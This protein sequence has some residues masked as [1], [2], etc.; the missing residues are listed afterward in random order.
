MSDIER[1][2][3][4]L[5]SMNTSD[6]IDV[7]DSVCDRRIYGDGRTV[8]TIQEKRDKTMVVI[9]VSYEHQCTCSRTIDQL[10]TEDELIEY[11]TKELGDTPDEILTVKNDSVSVIIPNWECGSK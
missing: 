5:K 2:I 4:L 6:L 1:A 3:N 10:M 9:G 7:L 8:W 11:M